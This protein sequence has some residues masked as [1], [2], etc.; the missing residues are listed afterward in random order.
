MLQR[1]LSWFLPLQKRPGCTRCDGQRLCPPCAAANGPGLTRRSVF[2]GAGASLA[3]LGV[4][5]LVAMGAAPVVAKR[6]V[7][8]AAGVL[9]FEQDMGPGRHG[10]R[11]RLTGSDVRFDQLF[12]PGEVF[13]HVG[14]LGTKRYR[15]LGFGGA[16][17]NEF[18]Q[19]ELVR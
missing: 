17:E 6:L 12:R 18:L 3:L 9:W 19:V 1:F 2:V 7:L 8:D 11:V 13:E 10:V 4:G 5:P 15:V 14:P 16:G